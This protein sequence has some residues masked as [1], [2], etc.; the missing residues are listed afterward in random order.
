MNI[1]SW[2]VDGYK[3]KIHKHVIELILNNKPDIIFFNET[4]QKAK[5]M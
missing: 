3:N 2:N 4:K 5:Q 1:I